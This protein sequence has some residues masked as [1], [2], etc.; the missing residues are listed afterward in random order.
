MT[1]TF[2]ASAAAPPASDS[3]PVEPAGDGPRGGDPLLAGLRTRDPVAERAFYER[4]VDRVFRLGV[5]MTGRE[6]LAA[7]CTQ[8]TFVRAF[9]RIDAFRG[10]SSLGTWLHAIAVSVVLN[11][12]RREKRVA[13]RHAPLEAIDDGGASPHVAVPR[14]AEPD[15]KVR[16]RAA[17]DALAPGYRAVFLMHDVEGY[18]HEEIGVALGVASGTSKTQLFHARRKLRDALAPFMRTEA[19]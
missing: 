10:D 12:L 2:A 16:L 14:E 3:R 4:H 19:V 18:T 15:L 6:D 5:R 7:E 11:A 1:G 17:I 8:D 13:Q 9:E